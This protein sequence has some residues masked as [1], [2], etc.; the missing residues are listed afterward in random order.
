MGA[1][2]KLLSHYSF[3][4][5]GCMIRASKRVAGR[6]KIVVLLATLSLT[7][8]GYAAGWEQSGLGAVETLMMVVDPAIVAQAPAKPAFIVSNQ[9]ETT[10]SAQGYE[11]VYTECQDVQNRNPN[12]ANND[13]S[14]LIGVPAQNGVPI[15][16]L[17]PKITVLEPPKHGRVKVID[18]AWYF[19]HFIPN[20]DYLGK[21]RVVYEIE[22]KGKRYKVTINFWVMPVVV[23]PKG[24]DPYVPD[25]LYQKFNG[26]AIDPAILLGASP[27]SSSPIKPQAPATT[28]LGT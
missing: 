16:K 14:P 21:D 11:N 27:A 10:G 15:G 24:D 25:C 9:S 19:Y 1:R 6:C 2:T 13:F 23:D 22:A 28:L 26:S 18:A 4:R 12:S 7:T 3:N 20:K 8:T 17:D 5:Q